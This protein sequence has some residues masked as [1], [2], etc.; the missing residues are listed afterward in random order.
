MSRHDMALLS[1]TILRFFFLHA[2][3]LSLRVLLLRH[4]FCS[5]SQ[6]PSPYRYGIGPVV[7]IA[8]KSI[9]SCKT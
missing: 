2:C 1:L 4:T 6:H 9:F 8:M 5:L 7:T 3:L